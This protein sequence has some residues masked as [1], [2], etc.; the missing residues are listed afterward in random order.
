MPFSKGDPNINRSGRPPIGDSWADLIKKAGELID[1]MTKKQFKV[2]VVEQLYLKASRGDISAIREIFDRT[3]G[4]PKM[5][6]ILPMTREESMSGID[7]DNPRLLRTLLL[8]AQ[9]A[10]RSYNLKIALPKIV[11][12]DVTSA[13]A[14]QLA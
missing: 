7:I 2:L 13:G 12:K 11:N 9:A 3:D 4:K 14:A 5:A 10:E 1:P 6:G 8:T